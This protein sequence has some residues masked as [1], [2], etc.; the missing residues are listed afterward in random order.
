MA[1][2]NAPMHSELP[3]KSKLSMKQDD[4]TQELSIDNREIAAS[5]IQV[6]DSALN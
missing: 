6:G 2:I 5:T 3:N 4:A 1:S